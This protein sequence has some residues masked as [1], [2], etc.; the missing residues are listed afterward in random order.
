MNA[1]STGLVDKGFDFG[2][3]NVH[4][5]KAPKVALLTGE[6]ISSN[7]AGE[8]W[9]F[10]EKQLNYPITLINAN[11]FSRVTGIILMY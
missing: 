2:S 10:F 5:L 11:D 9:H 7:A 6:G 4:P 8:I 3:D 1:V